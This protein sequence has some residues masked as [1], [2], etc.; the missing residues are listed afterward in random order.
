MTRARYSSRAGL[1]LIE[2]VAAI[3]VVATAAPAML[4]AIADST[5]QRLGPVMSS[6]AR[7]LAIERLE[8]VIADRHASG[9]GYGFVVNANYSAE[10]SITGF[11]G[12]TRGVAIVETGASLSGSGAGYKT[13][14]V[15]IT[16]LDPRRG[17]QSLQLA[18]VVTEYTP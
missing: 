7:W 16:W 15:T 5:V 9:R 10:P 8:D 11:P 18:T 4:W 17:N 3:V 14:T 13:V 2:L 6:R 12:F 1:T